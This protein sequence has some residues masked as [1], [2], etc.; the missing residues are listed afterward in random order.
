MKSRRNLWRGK[1]GPLGESGARYLPAKKA[2]HAPRSSSKLTPPRQLR[3]RQLG[4]ACGKKAGGD[5]APVDLDSLLVVAGPLFSAEIQE[6]VDGGAVLSHGVRVG[7]HLPGEYLVQPAVAVAAGVGPYR[8]VLAELRDRKPGVPED[9]RGQALVAEV[10]IAA[11]GQPRGVL[12]HHVAHVRRE[13]LLAHLLDNRVVE[14]HQKGV[15]EAPVVLLLELPADSCEG[16][17]ALDGLD[18]AVPDLNREAIAQVEAPPVRV[19]IDTGQGVGRHVIETVNRPRYLPVEPLHV[20]PHPGRLVL[21]HGDEHVEEVVAQL[22]FREHGGQRDRA[23]GRKGLRTHRLPQVAAE[24]QQR[25]RLDASGQGGEVA[26]RGCSGDMG[27]KVVALP[28]PGAFPDVLERLLRLSDHRRAFAPWRPR[29]S[30]SSRRR[31]PCPACSCR[32]RQ[33]PCSSSP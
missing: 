11:P 22:L 5:E 14:P 6:V 3:H 15:M 17:P 23:K 20:A 33:T 30:S 8:L 13:R 18:G 2:S 31:S 1:I 21:V 12:L 24:R 19:V 26:C 16:L 29:A 4:V 9:V 32:A 7:Q 10:E 25:A 27:A 28:A